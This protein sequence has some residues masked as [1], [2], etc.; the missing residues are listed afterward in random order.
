M[1]KS[2]YT[3]FLLLCLVV[4]SVSCVDAKSPKASNIINEKNAFRIIRTVNDE[5]RIGLAYIFP[6]NSEELKRLGYT[7]KQIQTYRFFLTSYVNTLSQTNKEKE[8]EGVS[9]SGSNYFLDVDGVG[10]VI[11]FENLAA[12]NKFYGVTQ[13]PSGLETNP[14]REEKGIFIKKMYVRT[15]FPFSSVKAAGDVKLVCVMAISAWAKDQ[16][17]SDQEKSEVL[18]VLDESMFIY[19]FA[20]TQFALKSDY[21]YDD[22]M[23]HHNV[24]VKSIDDIENNNQITFYLTQPNYPVW[25]MSALVFVVCGM[26]VCYIYFKKKKTKNK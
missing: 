20:S 1:K 23:F 18:E 13:N 8:I 16:G 26:I 14:K 4:V 17:L 11:D 10:F 2:V 5:G 22:A 7:D 12:Q 3:L 15:T 21:M 25:Y 6:S 9:V 24:F 19:D